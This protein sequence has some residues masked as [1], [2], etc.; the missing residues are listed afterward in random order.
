[1][2]FRYTVKRNNGFVLSKIFN[3]EEIEGLIF[4]QWMKANIININ[5]I[6]RDQFT[7]LNDINKKEIYEGDIIK[8]P[9]RKI[10]FK[11]HNG[12]PEEWYWKEDY[13]SIYCSI[14]DIIIVTRCDLTGGFHPFSDYDSDCGYYNNSEYFEIIGNIHKNPE[15]LDVI[16][17]L[18]PDADIEGAFKRD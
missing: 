10:K 17:D 7:G 15:L 11:A 5:N 18:D 2:K 3:L 13:P 1:M 14:G 12:D 4:N 8:A 9:D 16:V 6:I